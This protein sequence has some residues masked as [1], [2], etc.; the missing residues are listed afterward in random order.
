MKRLY[1]TRI[2]CA[3]LLVAIGTG[4]NAVA[5]KA[6]DA[7]PAPAAAK[8]AAPAQ[9]AGAV[10][11]TLETDKP[12]H[13]ASIY[14]LGSTWTRAD[15]EKIPLASL[16]G[17]VRV[18][19]IFYSSCEYACPIIVGRMKSVQA[20]LPEAGKDQA[21][22]VLVSMDVAHDDPSKLKEYSKRMELEGDWTLLRG[23]DGDV[24][25]LGALLGFRYRQEQDGG[26]SHSN[27]ITVLDREGRVVHQSIG[28]ETD[29]TDAVAAVSKL[30][31]P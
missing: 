12:L 6:P 14:Q 28:L 10:H 17:K 30:L 19:A 18:I 31:V 11:G 24:R 26:F 2:T 1:W 25:E 15:G 5:Q 29:V 8:D 9:A 4:G 20:A 27:M 7:A 13:D 21:G 23:S 22:F 16:R 3:A